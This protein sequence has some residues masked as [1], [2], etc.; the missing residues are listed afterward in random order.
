VPGLRGVGVVVVALLL[1]FL[2]SSGLLPVL[3]VEDFALQAAL[4]HQRLQG[5]G[6]GRPLRRFGEPSV[7]WIEWGYYYVMFK[8]FNSYI[9][10]NL[11]SASIYITSSTQQTSTQH[12]K[13]QAQTTSLLQGGTAWGKARSR[14]TC[15][16]SGM[17]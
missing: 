10:Q 11:P 1:D 12:H 16:G 13:Q 14:T 9:R 5:S 17:T 2:L 7:Y 4:R 6:Y 8:L 3:L 15:P